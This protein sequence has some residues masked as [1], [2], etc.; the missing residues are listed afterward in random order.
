MSRK[1]K[2][3][4]TK[5]TQEKSIDSEKRRD[6]RGQNQPENNGVSFTF[7]MF[8]LLCLI[9]TETD[10]DDSN[11]LANS[12]QHVLLRACCHSNNT[13]IFTKMVPTNC[14]LLPYT[15][16]SEPILDKLLFTE[17]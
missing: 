17:K 10:D 2:E 7:G 6:N 3:E 16:D 15:P 13:K 8:D 5:K 12:W 14:I 4:E 1:S 9:S 11:F